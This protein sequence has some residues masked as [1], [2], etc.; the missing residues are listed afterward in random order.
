MRPFSGNK[1]K[2][3]D[4][5]SPIVECHPAVGIHRA[6]C[7]RYIAVPNTRFNRYRNTATPSGTSALSSNDPILLAKDDP[8]N[9]LPWGKFVPQ[10]K[11]RERR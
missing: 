10:G 2:G 4:P 8:L 6:T 3:E 5:I 9:P 7:K 11:D 1:S